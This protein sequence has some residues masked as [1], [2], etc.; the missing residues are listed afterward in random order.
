MG[1][2]LTKKILW[3]SPF[4]APALPRN[5]PNRAARDRGCRQAGIRCAHCVEKAEEWE[6]TEENRIEGERREASR[7]GP[8]R[9]RADGND[10]NDGNRPLAEMKARFWGSGPRAT[11]IA[12]QRVLDPDWVER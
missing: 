8:Q 2:R 7:D 1:P 6:R 11:P 9:T 3:A 5:A 12:N 10:E 4:S